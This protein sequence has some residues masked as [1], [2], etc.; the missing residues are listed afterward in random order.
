[1]PQFQGK[2]VEIKLLGGLASFKIKPDEHQQSM[3]PLIEA[4]L[5]TSGN[6]HLL[7]NEITQTE[8]KLIKLNTLHE[9]DLI[10]QEE[11]EKAKQK[12]I[13]G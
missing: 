12:I 8:D 13:Q 1:M 6:Q 2:T 4:P 3:H 7:E 9:K 11:F 10:T 5:A